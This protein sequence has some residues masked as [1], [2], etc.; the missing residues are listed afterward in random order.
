MS[1]AA[2]HTLLLAF[3]QKLYKP[4]YVWAKANL[5]TKTELSQ[6]EGD[7]LHPVNINLLTPS[8]TF[9]KN[10]ILG[11]NGV[12]YRATAN[13]S[14]FPVTLTIDNGQFVFDE[15]NGKK[16]FVVSDPTVNQGWEQFM[17]AGIEYWLAQK[18]DVADV[19]ATNITVSGKTYTVRQLLE[20]LVYLM[21][22]TVVL[23]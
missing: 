14:N 17:D 4:I 2:I 9:T 15:V 20:A 21:G 23:E 12:L 10:S 11:I 7:H 5:A 22:K 6:N 18:A 16:A 8:S 19:L 1:N 3:I 13:T